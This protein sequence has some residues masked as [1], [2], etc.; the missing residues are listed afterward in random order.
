[1]PKKIRIILAIFAPETD[2]T[3]LYIGII[4]LLEFIALTA[5]MMWKRYSPQGVLFINGLIMIALAYLAGISYPEVQE[6]AGSAYLDIF[7]CIS[8]AFSSSLVN[9]GLMILFIGGYVSYM[10]KIRAND[11]LIRVAMRPLSLLYKHPYIAVTALIPLGQILFICIPSATGLAF[12]LAGTLMPLLSRIGIPRATALSAIA[13]C[14]IFDIG[15][16]SANSM[17]AASLAGV[18]YSH[19][20]FGYQMGMVVP[21]TLVLMV[22]FFFTSKWFDRRSGL[23]QSTIREGSCPEVRITKDYPGDFFAI[24]PLLPLLLMIVS[25]FTDNVLNFPVELDITVSIFISLLISMLFNLIRSRSIEQAF[26]SLKSF[27]DGMG[28]TFSG[29]ITLIAC[30][31]IFSQ[32]LISLG[33]VEGIVELSSAIGFQWQFIGLLITLA[34]FIVAFITG[35]SNAIFFSF[36]SMMPDIASKLGAQSV[37]MILPMQ[38]SASI[39]RSVSPIAGVIIAISKI[40]E[41]SVMEIIKRNMPPAL[42]TLLAM[43]LYNCLML[44]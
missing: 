9:G 11:A 10:R 19:Y 40:G 33:A 20:V 43:C 13:L 17:Y 35:S 3:M 1:M 44:A 38:L 23:A 4:I 25:G 21:L 37:S 31:E 36:G 16:G 18:S 12:L 27:W 22:T 29:I 32:G 39:G 30:A 28:S 34:I 15:P 14:T 41:V 2:L 8:K 42:V 5:Y 24:L 26:R 7:G 6:S